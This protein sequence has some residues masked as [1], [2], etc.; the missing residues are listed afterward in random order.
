MNISSIDGT[1]A[2]MKEVNIEDSQ[3]NQLFII[4]NEITG[5]YDFV[6]VSAGYCRMNVCMLC[7]LRMVYISL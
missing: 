5:E 7:L 2:I 4:S 1:D 3:I 6:S